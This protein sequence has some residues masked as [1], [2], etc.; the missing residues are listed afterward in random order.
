MVDLREPVLSSSI[1]QTCLLA[2][3]I[4]V[5]WKISPVKNPK[6]R[7]AQRMCDEREQFQANPMKS[8][9]EETART[10]HLGALE[11]ERRQLVERTAGGGK[12]SPP[13]CS[14]ANV[15]LTRG[16]KRR[17][18]EKRDRWPTGRSPGGKE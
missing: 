10:D 3:S 7:N 14:F 18:R 2:K 5:E 17:E 1:L 15:W 11:A 12:P 16:A 4:D 6:V 8:T 9:N 13:M